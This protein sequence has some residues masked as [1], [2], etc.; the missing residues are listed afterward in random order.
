MKAFVRDR[1]DNPSQLASS[2]PK[3]HFTSTHLRPTEPQERPEAHGQI[4]SA[5]AH[6]GNL[7]KA[8]IEATE[9]ELESTIVRLPAHSGDKNVS[10]VSVEDSR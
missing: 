6:L 3:L 7:G 9:F 2:S 1:E 10:D 8:K 4:L 5:V